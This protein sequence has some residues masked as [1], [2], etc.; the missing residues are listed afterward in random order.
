MHTKFLRPLFILIF[1]KILGWRIVG[2]KP[3][4]KKFVMVVAPHTSNWD[5]MVGSWARSSLRLNAWYVA[6]KELFVWP[7]G[8]LFRALGGFPVDRKKHTNLVDQIVE[9]FN[10]QTEFN[11]TI[12]PEGTRSYSPEWKTGFYQIALKANI[13]IQMVGFDYKKKLVALAEPFFPSGD[14]NKDMEMMKSYF[15]QFKGKYPE[16]GIL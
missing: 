6:K 3:D 12:T 16:K 5:F 15:R 4:F 2:K 8:Y 14:L 13:P 11:I 1:E 10:S 7:L 9:I